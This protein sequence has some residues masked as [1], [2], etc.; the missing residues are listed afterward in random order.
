ME[1]ERQEGTCLRGASVR[2]PGVWDLL[3]DLI[4]LGRGS[5]RLYGGRKH[6]FVREVDPEVFEVELFGFNPPNFQRL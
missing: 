4:V 6:I 1:G 5:Q 3:W 2:W